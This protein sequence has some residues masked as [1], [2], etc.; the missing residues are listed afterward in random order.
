[1]KISERWYTMWDPSHMKIRLATRSLLQIHRDPH[2]QKFTPHPPWPPL[3][4]VLL[5]IHRDPHYQFYSRMMLCLAA[6]ILRQVL[7]IVPCLASSDDNFYDRPSKMMPC[8][9]SSDDNFYDRPSKLMPCLATRMFTTALLWQCPVEQAVH[10]D[11]P[12]S[13]KNF[14]TDPQRWGSV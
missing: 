1:M 6:T 7:Q 8:L 11:D 13:Y 2:Y 5:H 9:A 12:S 10:D 14:M 4:E 3:P